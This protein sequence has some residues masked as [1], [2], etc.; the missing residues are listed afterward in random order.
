MS[1]LELYLGS[2]SE[3]SIKPGFLLDEI[4]LRAIID[5]IKCRVKIQPSIAFDLGYDSQ[6]QLTVSDLITLLLEISHPSVQ[7]IVK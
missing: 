2:K 7:K 5:A 3:D 1:A 6:F 4:H